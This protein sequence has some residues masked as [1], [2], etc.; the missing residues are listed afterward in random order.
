MTTTGRGYAADTASGPASLDVRDDACCTQR[1]DKALDVQ[2]EQRLAPFDG[3]T[4]QL[5]SR[6]LERLLLD[7]QTIVSLIADPR[8]ELRAFDDWWEHDGA[9][10]PSQVSSWESLEAEVADAESLARTSPGEYYV[11][12]AWYATD[13]SFLL[14]WYI[15][16]DDARDSDADLTGAPGLIRSA[17]ANV[18]NAA[19]EQSYQWFLSRR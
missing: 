8:K 12:R 14:R 6:P 4:L 19:I 2:F 1:I 10:L 17:A 3:L 5:D 15:D 11:R 16:L 13:C 9:I 18:C 7:L